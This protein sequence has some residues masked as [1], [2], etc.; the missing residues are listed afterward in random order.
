MGIFS[1]SKAL[2]TANK[3]I[4]AVDT[5]QLACA[6]ASQIVANYFVPFMLGVIFHGGY[7]GSTRFRFRNYCFNSIG[8]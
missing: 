4:K 3:R 5:K 2:G 8:H 1:D 6:P 7:G